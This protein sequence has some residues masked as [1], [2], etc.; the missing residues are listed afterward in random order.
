MKLSCIKGLVS[1]LF[2][3][4]LV[5]SSQ[6]QNNF[7]YVNN[8]GDAQTHAVNGFSVASNGA[9]TLIPG[10]PFLTGGAASGI[11][12]ISDTIVASTVGNFL[13]VPNGNSSSITVFSVN[14]ETGFLTPVPGS[15]FPTG[16]GNDQISLTVTSDNRFLYAVHSMTARIVAFSIGANGALTPV[17]GSPFFAGNIL[18]GRAKVSPDNRLLSVALDNNNRVSVLSIAA[19]GSLTPVPGSPFAAGNEDIGSVQSVDINCAGNLLF[20]GQSTPGPSR[21]NVFNI[22][23]NGSLTALAGSPFTIPEGINSEVILLSPDDRFL[24]IANEGSRSVSVVAVGGD[25]TLT[26]VPGSPFILGS[27][28]EEDRVPQDLATNADGTLLY[29]TNGDGTLSVFSVASNGV[30]TQVPG[31]PFPGGAGFGASIAAFPTKSCQPDFD[32]CLQNNRSILRFNSTTGDYTFTDC[33]TGFTLSG[34]GNVITRGC[35]IVLEDLEHGNK[36]AATVNTCKKK[37]TALVV[38]LRP[39]RLFIINDRDISNNTCGCPA[40]SQ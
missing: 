13:Y 22:A 14:P 16:Q 33:P 39:L 29:T 30:L 4:L 24:F 15:P 10:S 37:G 2:L 23:A 36:V 9:L 19:D 32:I 11:S 40:S 21:I 12:T 28:I 5:T 6:A 7:L 31:S 38:N 18:T 34:T 8:S 17:P 1:A 3:F 35:H 27:P 25:G 20:A 26:P